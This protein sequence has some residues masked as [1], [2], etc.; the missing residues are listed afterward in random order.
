MKLLLIIL[1]LGLF[2]NASGQTYTS[3][4]KALTKELPQNSTVDC[5]WVF[6][7]DEANVEKVEKLLLKAVI[8]NFEF[9]NVTLTNYLGWHINQGRCL[10][11]FDSSKPKIVLVEPLWYGDISKQLTTLFIGKKFQ[12]QQS[13]LSFLSELHSLMQVGSSYKFRE[14]SHTDSLITYDLG[15]FKGD[16]Y[17][18]GGN[19]TA[20]TINNNDDGVWRKI[21]IDTKDFAIIRYT[22]VNPVTNDKKIIQ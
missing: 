3:L 22:A 1:S 21:E 12:D 11:L 8:P 19:G 14:T 5:K 13:L 18:K 16:S 17:T 7:S 10:V 2:V 6:Y 20:T 9:Y 4:E 15:Y